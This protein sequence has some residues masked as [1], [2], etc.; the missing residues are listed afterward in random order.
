MKRSAS[1]I[2]AVIVAAVGLSSCAGAGASVDTSS[3]SSRSGAPSSTPETV[4]GPNGET[5]EVPEGHVYV[6][7]G[8]M[9]PAGGPG[10]C[11]T[12]SLVNITKEGDGPWI[13]KL[14]GPDLVDMGEREFAH[15][16]V[17]YADDGRIATY[18]VAPGDALY[19]ISDRFCM[20]GGQLPRLHG[21]PEGY[22]A[23]QPG[24]VLVLNPGAIP[25]FVYVSP[26]AE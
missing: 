4:T 2:L 3:E 13:A 16:E 14:L 7:D 1:V 17:G 15:G 9:I 23:L 26:Y 19:A 6:G 11:A 8:V 24:D 18:T 5:I 22:G 25:D 20:N 21:N 12:T 10:D